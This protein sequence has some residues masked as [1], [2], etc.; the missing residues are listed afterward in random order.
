MSRP[1]VQ[2]LIKLTYWT[3]SVGSCTG[4][5]AKNN[6]RSCDKCHLFSNTWHL[7]VDKWQVSDAVSVC[8][9]VE[10]IPIKGSVAVPTWDCDVPTL[11]LKQSRRGTIVRAWLS[12]NVWHGLIIRMLPSLSLQI[13]LGAHHCAPNTITN[14]LTNNNLIYVWKN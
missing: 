8:L 12:S 9:P 4:T 1:R 7:L 14:Q 11:G 6:V 3:F 10:I 2:S 5:F 13:V